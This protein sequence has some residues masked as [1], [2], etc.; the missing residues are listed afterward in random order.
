[1]TA[2]PALVV[3]TAGINCDLE[4]EQA[5]RTAGFAPE[6][7]H[8]NRLARERDPFRRYRLVVFPGGFSYG[9]DVASGKVAAVEVAALFG[10]A[11]AGYLR[12]G[13]LLLG[14]CNGFQT[15]VKMGLLPGPG[16]GAPRFTLAHN[17]SRKFEARWVR[18]RAPERARSVFVEPGETLELPVAHGEGRLAADAPDGALWLE[19]EGRVGYRYAPR[20]QAPG[21]EG[22]PVY[23]DDPNG[24]LG[25]VAGLSDATGRVFGLMPHPERFLRGWNH[26]R[27]T[28]AADPARE[29]E[30]EGDGLRLFR[31]AFAAAGQGGP[32]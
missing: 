26:P 30:R 16:A 2:P 17:G 10:G 25:G 24:S 23:P 18:L 6:R 9:D 21:P 29:A 32:A 5:L 15:L 19:R 11:L 1:M 20:G 4:T 3:R 14:I 27:W 28:R 22:R 31:R 7:V 12:R 13:G 8:A